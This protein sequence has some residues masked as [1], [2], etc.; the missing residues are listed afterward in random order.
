MTDRSQPWNPF[1]PLSGTE[2]YLPIEDYGL[3]GDCTT[4]A[5]V[6]RDGALR[7]LCLPRFDSDAVFCGLLDAAR[8]GRFALG[9]MGPVESRQLYVEDTG[10]LQT[11]IRNAAGCIRITDACTFPEGVDLSQDASHA[12]GELLRH[13][14][15][16]HGSARLRMEVAP[17]GGAHVESCEGGLRLR[18]SRFPGLRNCIWRLRAR[19][20]LC[21]SRSISTSASASA[22]VCA[23]P[24]SRRTASA[25][26]P[27][28]SSTPCRRGGDGWDRAL[29]RTAARA[30]AAFRSDAQAARLQPERRHDRRT[31]LVLAGENRRRTQLGL[32]VHVGKGCR[33]FGLCAARHRTVRRKRFLPALGTGRG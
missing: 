19:S 13:V 25:S 27:S 31:D 11:E 1:R 10:V 5:L 22:S 4:A 30:R 29:R 33:L 6:G 9:L 2:D 15:V 12:R 28:A 18:C 24:R 8:G 14:E 23:G 3:V 26:R 20:M 16:L 21:S 17:R 7:W 32:P